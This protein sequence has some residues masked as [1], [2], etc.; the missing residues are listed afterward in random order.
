MV[1]ATLAITNKNITARK[2]A[3]N[4]KQITKEKVYNKIFTAK[5]KQEILYR[6]VYRELWCHVIYMAKTEG[7]LTNIEY[8]ER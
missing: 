3:K 6:K 5:K 8:V 7:K 1:T 4:K 2:K